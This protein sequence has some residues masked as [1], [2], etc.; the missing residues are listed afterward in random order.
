MSQLKTRLRAAT[1]AG[2]P[3][4][5]AVSAFSSV[6]DLL[7]EDLDTAIGPTVERLGTPGADPACL[8]EIS[9]AMARTSS[10][11]T[12]ARSGRRAG[13]AD[14]P[15]DPI[16]PALNAGRGA[17]FAAAAAVIDGLLAEFA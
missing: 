8:R 16:A 1:A 15:A 9:R 17:A 5:M 14:A 2:L 6:R 7:A 4:R 13:P 10:A 11:Y 3:N 12:A